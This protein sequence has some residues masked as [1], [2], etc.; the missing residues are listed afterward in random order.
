MKTYLL[1]QQ[2]VRQVATFQVEDWQR[3]HCAVE[4]TVRGYSL[5]ESHP[6]HV[7]LGMTLDQA[8]LQAVREDMGLEQGEEWPELKEDV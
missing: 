5:V 6:E 3:P 1:Y 8:V 4:L 7:P 2:G